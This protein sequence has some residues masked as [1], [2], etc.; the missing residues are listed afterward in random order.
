MI[1]KNTGGRY[2]SRRTDGESRDLLMQQLSELTPGQRKLV[3]AMLVSATRGD[4]S[5]FDYM[6]ESR[7]LR[8]PVSVKQFLEDPYYMGNSS[9]TLYPRIKEDLIDMFETPGIREVVLTGSIGYGKTTFI[10]FA[11]IR[12]LYE[13]SCLRA[14]Q[15]AYGLSPG[16]EI[17]IA[18]MSKSLHLARQVMKS[19]VD[20]K[21][22]LSPY[23]MEQ[24]KP[25]FRA[26]STMFPNNI[27]LSIGSCFSERIL[28]MNVLGGALDEA[29]F[30]ISKGQVIGKNGG[31]KA[32]VAQFDLA[33]KMYAS[34][35]RRIKSRFLKAP[36]DLPGLMI[37][38]S[39][40]ATIDSFTNRKIRDSVSDPSVF[41]RDYAAWDVKPKQNFNGE[42]F[43]VLIGNSAVRSKVIKDKVDADAVDRGWLEEQ[44]CR[45]IE[46]P[47]EYYDD[48][49]RD[50]ENGIRDIAGIST[51]AISAFM[52]RI[53]RI[54]DCTNRNVAHPFETTEYEYGSGAKF[55]W[56]M[57]CKPAE[58]KLPGGYKE[59]Y[60]VP[61]RNP[62]AA[63]SIHI[64]PSLSGDST[65]F[66]MG[67]IE[68]WVEVVR[69]GPDGE[70]YSDVAPH[71][72]VDL[73]L[74]INPP[75]GEQIFLPD[76]RRMVYELQD[77]G[78]HLQSF[79]CD[80]YQSAEM[81]QQMKARGVKADVVSVDRTMDAYDALKSAIYEQRIEFYHYEPFIAELRALEYDRVRGKVDHPVA[82]TKDVADAVAGMVYSLVKNANTSNV[83][84]PDIDLDQQESDAWVSGSKIMLPPNSTQSI[85]QGMVSTPLPFI[86]G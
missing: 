55:L 48:F 41:V 63:R 62:K 1:D 29:N 42:K 47:I 72:V 36:Q 52:S 79:S 77:H 2:Q 60:W 19:A 27:S 68:R 64:D 71:I 43:W 12:L 33:E 45:I 13:L 84:M 34:I 75:Q 56:N 46:V 85:A 20:D 32:T 14:P 16:S 78:F 80:S 69:R 31:K 8:K 17:V 9:Q 53:G 25:E 61:L 40:A 6:N 70:E 10:S 39:S 73:M 58:R 4:S 7:W 65:G 11:T 76:I 21:I 81:V 38:A 5:L 82:G 28:G 22:K 67:H 26:D 57:L 51:H 49:D 37:L 24:F 30:M 18:L 44:E 23:F 59:I 3:Q 83:I 15:L 66:A 54:E 35:V 50:L 86:M 74:R